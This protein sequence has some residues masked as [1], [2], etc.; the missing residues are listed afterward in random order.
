MIKLIRP[1]KPIEL[2]EKEQKELTQEYFESKKSKSV[3]NRDYIRRALLDSTNGKCC[4]CEK[5]IG[6]GKTDMHI[7]HFKPKSKYPDSVVEWDN[8]MPSCPD[9]NR[10]KNDHDTV[11]KSIVNPY[12]DNPKEYFYLKL[13]RYILE[14]SNI[15]NR[16]L[17]SFRIYTQMQNSTYLCVQV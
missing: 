6:S 10:S 12:V 17:Q 4:Y 8:L 7:D 2:S 15:W 11:E 1:Q 9:C 16:Y 14:R 5:K 3:W 13:C